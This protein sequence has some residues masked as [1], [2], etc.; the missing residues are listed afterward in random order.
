FP[1]GHITVA[2]ANS[3]ASLASRPIRVV[4]CDAFAGYPASAGAEGAPVSLA[5]KRTATFDNRRFVLVSTPTFEGASRIAAAYEETDR[6]VYLVPCPDPD[7][8]HEQELVWGDKGGDH[9]VQWDKDD[10]G[11]PIPATARY[12]CEACGA[13]WSDGD[14]WKAV[15]KGRWHATAPFN[16]KAG[17]RLSALYSP[18]ARLADIVS[19]HATAPFN[20]KAGFRLSALYSPWAR[21]ADIVREW[22]EALGQSERIKVFVNTVLGRTFRELGE[23]PDWQRIYDRR[24]EWET[25]RVPAGARLL[26]GF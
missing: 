21:L 19:W 5:Y 26:T 25:A 4:L 9:G 3:A 1:G 11:R 20:G 22:A 16:G 23:A 7:C 8:G 6:R 24:E 10:A 15:A 12:V 14:R 18:W 17:F 2:G 13:V